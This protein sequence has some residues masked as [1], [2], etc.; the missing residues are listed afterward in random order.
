MRV[1]HVNSLSGYVPYWQVILDSRSKSCI[2][3]SQGCFVLQ[4]YYCQWLYSVSCS[5]IYTIFISLTIRNCPQTRC[6]IRA[7]N[8]SVANLCN[9]FVHFS[10]LFPGSF[11]SL[12]MPAHGLESLSLC[13][14]P[15]TTMSIL[16]PLH[17]SQ[18]T[19]TGHVGALAALQLMRNTPFLHCLCRW[20]WPF[21]SAWEL[22][23]KSMEQLMKRNGKMTHQNS[24]LYIEPPQTV[25]FLFGIFH[26]VFSDCPFL[27]EVCV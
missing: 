5:T 6:Q 9:G 24:D 27:K 20:S 8:Y 7:Q 2:L 3:T 25:G 13:N 15:K 22:I 11:R 21:G 23:W 17:N 16:Q 14:M 19:L 12:A 1:Y 10:K 18:L 4:I 26:R